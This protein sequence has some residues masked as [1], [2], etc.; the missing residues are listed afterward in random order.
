MDTTTTTRATL[1]AAALI[2]ANER[3]ENEKFIAALNA[4]LYRAQGQR[5][6]LERAE[7]DAQDDLDA[8]DYVQAG[9]AYAV[10]TPVPTP[11]VAAPTNANATLYR[12]AEHSDE[13][14]RVRILGPSTH[15]GLLWVT[16]GAHEMF[17]EPSLLRTDEDGW[18]QT[19]ANATL[20]DTWSPA[21]GFIGEGKRVT[22]TGEA[23]HIPGTVM[24]WDGTTKRQAS[25]EMIRMDEES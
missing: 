7:R 17:V 16:D 18:G 2:A 5:E 9:K 3:A 19:E 6:R 12:D 21:E 13:G 20:Y 23:G 14:T 25:P 11:T 15:P 4:A 8:Y 10:I 24:I 22:V 1:N